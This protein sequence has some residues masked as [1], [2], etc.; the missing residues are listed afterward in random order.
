MIRTRWQLQHG[1]R[2]TRKDKYKGTKY[3]VQS[4][5]YKVPMYKS[6][7]IGIGA[8]V[9]LYITSKLKYYVCNIRIICNL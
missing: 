8:L 1:A 4:T 2:L 6:L 9:R 3:K 5:K 7:Q